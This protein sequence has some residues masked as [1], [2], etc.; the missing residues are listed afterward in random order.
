MRTYIRECSHETCRSFSY[1]ARWDVLEQLKVELH[2][3][4]SPFLLNEL[5]HFQVIT[6]S[7]NTQEPVSFFKPCEVHMMIQN[8]WNHEPL[9]YASFIMTNDDRWCSDM[10]AL[11]LCETGSVT[12]A[13][14]TW[15]S[16]WRTKSCWT[17]H[18]AIVVSPV[19]W[20]RF[21]CL[22]SH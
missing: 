15:L 18:W 5:K 17:C 12:S 22:K 7:V 2:S 3:V 19:L 10:C 21:R 9:S 6:F 11:F 4:K 1:A 16:M 8:Y 20:S 14:G 13:V